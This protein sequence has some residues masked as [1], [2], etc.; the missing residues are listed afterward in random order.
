MGQIEKLLARLLTKP[1]DFTNEEADTLLVHLGYQ[2]D[3]K[4]KTSG[5][6]IAYIHTKSKAVFLLHRAHPGN[7]LKPY[8][9]KNLIQHLKEQGIIHEQKYS[10]L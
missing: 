5:S 3:T 8:V 7:T 10:N 9:I 1:K 2:K 4:G 6:R